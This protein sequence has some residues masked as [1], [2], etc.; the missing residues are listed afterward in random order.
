MYIY[1]YDVQYIHIYIYIMNFLVKMAIAAMYTPYFQ[2]R[3]CVMV[4]ERSCV[5]LL[6][7]PAT[8]YYIV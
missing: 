1:I 2:T 8:T 5:Q 7:S 4:L 3:P 6:M